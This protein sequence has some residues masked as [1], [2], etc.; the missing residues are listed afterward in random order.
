VRAAA[1]VNALYV[2]SLAA[3]LGPRWAEGARRKKVH[4]SP[5]GAVAQ[6]SEGANWG[7]MLWDTWRAGTVCSPPSGGRSGAACPP[8]QRSGRARAAAPPR[9]PRNTQGAGDGPPP[10]HPKLLLRGMRR[11]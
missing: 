8:A 3:S 6:R 1:G 2:C 9:G 5:S 11:S 4:V 10:H 7:S